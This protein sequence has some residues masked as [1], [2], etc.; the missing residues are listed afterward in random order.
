MATKT[1]TDVYLIDNSD[2]KVNLEIKIGAQGQTGNTK[3]RL[4]G[5]SFEKPIFEGNL[6]STSIDAN[7][8]L[9]KKKL[10]IITT[11]T[12]TSRNTNY[13]SLDII[14][15]G[16]LNKK[17]YSL[18]KTVDSEGKSADYVCIIKFFDPTKP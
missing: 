13:T 18:N 3:I 6:S 15:T 17:T 8:L 9:H 5:G 10:E 11:I 2:K 7:K 1:L 16:G 4:I 12:D 14:L